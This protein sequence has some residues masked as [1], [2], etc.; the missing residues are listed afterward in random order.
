MAAAV[1]DEGS[2]QRFDHIAAR[3]G[4]RSGAASQFLRASAKQMLMAP[5]FQ[6]SLLPGPL[7]KT[8]KTAQQ[9]ALRCACSSIKMQHTK[10]A[11]WCILKMEAPGTILR[12]IGV[13]DPI[14]LAPMKNRYSTCH[15]CHKS[16]IWSAMKLLCPR[17]CL[18][19]VFARVTK[20]TSWRAKKGYFGG[21]Q[22]W[23]HTGCMHTSEVGG[24]CSLACSKV[25]G[26][27]P[28]TL[29]CLLTAMTGKKPSE[30]PGPLGYETKPL[31]LNLAK[32]LA[33]KPAQGVS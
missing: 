9:N 22:V 32:H 29:Q 30:T 21:L 27:S 12:N 16:L 8:L 31:T 7:V 18:R 19:R 6:S 24:T 23:G 13:C 17:I 25:G 15:N 5:D 1:R 3:D 28:E 20:T 10:N 11:L 33:K 4:I 26:T 2:E 14:S